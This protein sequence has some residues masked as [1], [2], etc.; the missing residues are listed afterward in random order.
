MVL[1]LLLICLFGVLAAGCSRT[2]FE[3]APDGVS[4]Q[5]DQRL[6][7]TWIAAEGEDEEE[8]ETA[9][10]EL[11]EEDADYILVTRDCQILDWYTRETFEDIPNEDVRFIEG[12]KMS[13]A[14]FPSSFE[15]SETDEATGE[16]S[17]KTWATGYE[18]VRYTVSGDRVAVYQIDHDRI[19]KMIKK[20]RI[21]RGRTLVTNRDE[22]RDKDYE[23]VLKNFVPGT[24]QRTADLLRSRPDIFYARPMYVLHRYKGTPPAR[25]DEAND[26]R[27][28]PEPDE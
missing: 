13:Y 24:S 23:P 18:L 22:S 21:P 3:S 2:L 15:I 5:C 11:S 20:K 27:D 9:R 14:Y 19:A 10:E 8:E 25:S 6:I 1:R 12:E 17:E 7:G 26:G 28:D 4:T 16:E